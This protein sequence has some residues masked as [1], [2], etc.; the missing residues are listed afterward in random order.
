MKF[1]DAA[2]KLSNVMRFTVDQLDAEY[3]AAEHSFRVAILS[4]AMAEEYNENRTPDMSELCV[5]ET[6]KKA[7]C[8]DWEESRVG[9]L[10][11]PLKQFPGFK[12]LY[13]QAAEQAMKE[14]VLVDF[15]AG[16]EKLLKLWK[17]DKEGLSGEVIQIADKLEAFCACA[18]ELSRGN[19]TMKG[20][21]ENI[22]PWFYESKNAAMMAKF[23]VS[24]KILN[25]AETAAQEFFDFR[26]GTLKLAG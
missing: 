2:C 15:P 22:R 17:E 19:L 5:L 10:M 21:Y 1:Y 26:A 23:K 9:D 12:A 14:E 3:S 25:D 7:L 24:L 11:S 18:H 8:H 6:L 4:L 20:P 13:S 16:K